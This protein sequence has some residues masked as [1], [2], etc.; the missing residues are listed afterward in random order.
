[1]KLST[2]MPYMSFSTCKFGLLLLL[3]AG[4]AIS[5]T[6]QQKTPAVKSEGPLFR[7]LQLGIEV[8]GP[9]AW[10]F[11]SNGSAS[12]KLDANLS[13][14][15]FPTLEIGLSHFD[16]TGQTGNHF[17][18]TGQYAK[19]GLNLPIVQY[20][21]KADN[22][23]YVGL[24]Y[25]FSSF[26]Y[27]LDHLSLSENYWSAPTL[28]LLQEQAIAGW[29]EALAGIRVRVAGPVSAGWSLHYKSLLHCSN[30]DHSVPPYIPG[31]GQHVKPNAALCAHVYVSIL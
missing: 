7:G 29:F 11:S 14:H 9:A 20:G 28:S 31:Y 27:D 10:L 18:S 6:A 26:Q 5:S 13:N 17:L 25:G 22:L 21:S 3:L 23:F 19:L 30:G 16:K 24:H 8:G 4:C 2:T 1:M 12:V 15:Y